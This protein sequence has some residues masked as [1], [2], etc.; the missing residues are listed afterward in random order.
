MLSIDSVQTQEMLKGLEESGV[1]VNLNHLNDYLGKKIVE[2]EVSVSKKGLTVGMNMKKM[3]VKV[4]SLPNTLRSFVDEQV[5][6]GNISILPKPLDRKIDRI[7]RRLR[8]VKDRLALPGSKGRYISYD[9]F[10]EFMEACDEA[11]KKME[12]T[13]EEISALWGPITAQ[14]KE[15]L[16]STL[17]IL[18]NGDL[19]SSGYSEIVSKIPTL[20]QFNEQVGLEIEVRPFP[21]IS[22]IQMM[23]FSDN[24]AEQFKETSHNEIVSMV[25]ATVGEAL[26]T[27]FANANK[28][29]KASVT[30]EKIPGK[31]LGKAMTMASDIRKINVFNNPAVEEIAKIYDTIAAKRGDMEQQATSAELAMI[32][33]WGYAKQVGIDIDLTDC[34]IKKSQLNSMAGV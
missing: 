28:I 3:G 21:V 11:K 5:K 29:V 30:D 18:N 14:F 17:D 31:S 24:I 16:R 13:K 25:Q 33:I 2:V 7:E 9:Q 32:K 15:K 10:D 22:Q 34:V 19:S 20:E 23:N 6:G 27:A 8:G 12:E 4:S 1:K 26:N